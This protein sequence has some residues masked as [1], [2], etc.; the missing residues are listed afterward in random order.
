MEPMSVF[1]LSSLALANFAGPVPSS[2]TAD[3]YQQEIDLLT[4]EW[5]EHAVFQ[6]AA[7]SSD[8]E[9]SL[10][11]TDVPA[12]PAELTKTDD[13]LIFTLALTEQTPL[14][15]VLDLV[16]IREKTGEYMQVCRRLSGAEKNAHPAQFEALD[17]AK[18]TFHDE[19]AELLQ[20]AFL[21]VQTSTESMR[22]L[23]SLLVSLLETTIGAA[24]RFHR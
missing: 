7:S 15:I 24:H 10:T 4:Q 6:M 23:F 12:L 9:S 21:P 17:I 2:I 3:A 19:A 8:R 11:S 5:I 1:R 14:Q 13:N 18:R 20:A 16:S 22:R